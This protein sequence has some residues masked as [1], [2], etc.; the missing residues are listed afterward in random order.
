MKNAWH[1][2]VV[3]VG[4]GLGGLAAA[5]TAH[6]FG[7]RALIIEKS[8]VVGGVTAWSGGQLW[9]PGNHLAPVHGIADTWQAGADYLERIGGGSAHRP[10]LDV[11]C[12][13]TAEA[14]SYFEDL[15]MRWQ[16]IVGLPDYSFGVVQD[17]L[18]EGR[19]LEPQ[20]FLGEALGEWRDKIRNYTYG[21]TS[22][23]QLAVGGIANYLSWDHDKVA[24]RERRDVRCNGAALSGWFAKMALDRGVAIET[25]ALVSEL[26][27]TR[28]AAGVRVTGVRA[29]LADGVEHQI[30]ASRGVLL[31][32][33]GYDW[34]SSLVDRY[35]GHAEYS[36]MAPRR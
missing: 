6:E 10:L 15:G 4:G 25:G 8:G 32:T 9:A 29:V 35:D 26:I 21:L 12:E 24:D 18:P 34:N 14:V 5:I 36:S 33:G 31:A 1:F 17:G 11:L 23:E 3:C 7:L 20:L 22:V 27:T 16:V 30:F 28:S 2:D 19:Y 13:R